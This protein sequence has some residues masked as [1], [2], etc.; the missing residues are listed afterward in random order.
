[1]KCEI[2]IEN[3]HKSQ[4]LNFYISI[5]LIYNAHNWM[6]HSHLRTIKVINGLKF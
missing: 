1:M 4:H 5:H 6:L 3:I 2:T